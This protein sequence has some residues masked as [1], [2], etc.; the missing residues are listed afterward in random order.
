MKRAL[1]LI[2][3]CAGISCSIFRSRVAPYPTGVIFPLA[4]AARIG[5][6][7]K[8]IRSLVGSEGRL[9]FSTDK[10]IV[11]CLE[12]AGL[13]ILWTYAAGAALGCPPA[14]GVASTAV[15]DV[16][17]NVHA[18]DKNG[19]LI[20]KTRLSD[21]ITSDI[22]L[23]RDRIYVGTK[24]GR[25]YAMNASSGEVLWSFKAE[26]AIEAACAV[27]QDTVVLGSVDGRLYLLSPQGKLL[28]KI[29]LG[30]ALRITPLLEG[31]RLYF[32]TD[33][34]RFGCLD[35]KSRKRKWRMRTDGKVLSPAVADRKRVYFAASNTVLYALNKTSGDMDW[36]CILPSRSSYRPELAGQKILAAS[37]S[38]VV[39]CLDRRTG[40]ES[41]RFEAGSELRSNPVWASPEIFVILYDFASGKGSLM[42]LRKQVKVELAAA[43]GSPGTVGT[44]VAVTASAVG[45]YLPKYEFFIRR[46]GETSVTQKESARNAWTWFPDK[47]GKFVI[48]VRVRDAKETKEAELSFDIGK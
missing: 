13:K 24:E 14:V 33:D 8:I 19:G 6:D 12:E 36:W 45:F 46:D 35:L 17:N 21:A 43:P 48:G 3:I 2:L 42:D 18:I 16:E 9:Y 29:E 22:C 38:P 1:T 28:D 41:G 4:E 23:G 31:D 25:L 5:F 39:V 7:G 15:W 44:E 40:Q 11:Y 47:V 30:A 10:G 27:W 37:S 20:W 32:G 26:G 34:A